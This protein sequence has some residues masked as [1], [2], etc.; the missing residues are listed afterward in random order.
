MKLFSRTSLFAL[1]ALL[2]TMAPAMAEQPEDAEVVVT[3]TMEFPED[4]QWRHAFDAVAGAAG[5]SNAAISRAVAFYR[6]MESAGVDAARVQTAVVVHGPAIYD[7]ANAARYQKQYGEATTNPNEA[8]VA[9]LIE[10]GGEIWV[11]GAAARGRRVGDS[12][13]LPG[14]R[15][16]PA[17]MVAHAELQR[18]GFGINPY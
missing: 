16:A 10:R 17:A 12:D 9:E 18:R 13:L 15:M 8:L 1:F 6:L 11:C 2:A 14:V 4:G 7:V 5:E 3:P